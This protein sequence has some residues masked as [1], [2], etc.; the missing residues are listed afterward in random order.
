MFLC[1]KRCLYFNLSKS[2]RQALEDEYLPA[3]PSP[4]SPGPDRVD[5]VLAGVDLK[6]Q[7]TAWGLQNLDRRDGGR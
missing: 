1:A 5:D 7:F 3:C 2:N 4:P 6:G